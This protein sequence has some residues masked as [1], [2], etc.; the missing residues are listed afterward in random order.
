MCY[1]LTA[2]LTSYLSLLLDFPF[3]G[4][5]DN[6]K[7]MAVNSLITA[8][9]V[10]NSPISHLKSEKQIKLNEEGMLAAATLEC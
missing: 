4:D 2:L 9:C 6:I 3:P 1:V 5:Y 10:R 7:I 8:S